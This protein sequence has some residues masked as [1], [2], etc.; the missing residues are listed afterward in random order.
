[1]IA[2]LSQSPKYV[3]YT[4]GKRLAGKSKA[5]PLVLAE[6]AISGLV[7]T[8]QVP[9]RVALLLGFLVSLGSIVWSIVQV[10]LVIGFGHNA[11]PGIATVAVAIFFFGGLQL[12][13]TGLLGEYVL[14]IHRQV[15]KA[16]AV[17]TKFISNM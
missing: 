5:S 1:L 13:F 14:S 12:F 6:V 2:Q 10:I 16:P 17:K 15:K 11:S 7:S 9:A 4:W 8:T 3:E